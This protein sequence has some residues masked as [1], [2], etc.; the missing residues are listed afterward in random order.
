MLLYIHKSYEEVTM[1]APRWL[2]FQLFLIFFIVIGC[3]APLMAGVPEVNHTMITDVTALSFSV[4]WSANEA[5]AA[6]LEV[7]ED[8]EGLI[9]FDAAVVTPHPVESGNDSIRLAAEDNGVMKVRV[10]GLEAGN[11]Y[12][13]K[14]LT[15]S[16][17]TMDTTEYPVAPPY[18]SITTEIATVKSMQVGADEIPFSND[19]I[20]EPCYLDDG[21]TPAEGTLLIAT[22]E[23]ADYPLTSFVG[24]GVELPNAL[25]DLNNTFGRDSKEN[26]DLEQGKNLTLLNFRGI[27]GNSIVTHNVPIDE[28]LSEV[29]TAEF[30]IK[31]GWNMV[32]CQLEP[33][34][35]NVESLLEPVWDNFHSLWTLNENGDWI[36][37]TK[38]LPW[39]MNDLN[40]I[41]SLKGYWL[42][43]EA[44]YQSDTTL[45]IHGTFNEGTIS[46]NAGWNLI[47]N[48][49]I[50]TER[51]TEAISPYSDKLRV[52]WTYKDGNWLSYTPGLPPFMNDLED[53][54]PG[55]GYMVY[56]NEPHD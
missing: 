12:Y 42:V 29:K 36:S 34:T 51:I 2:V 1:G 24:D 37:Y 19:I 49:S 18:T 10:T 54:K 9:P 55:Q 6:R 50:E 14:T 45:K 26:L 43:M 28:S 4:I 31:A 25:I 7:F 15:T 32:S 38:G 3:V 33:N 39:F 5:S 53:A 44:N 48:H 20:I 11:T 40:E 23:G 56:M 47:G 22:M 41:Y 13:F 30:A 8:E 27:L 17:S 21:I 52:I 16:L 35:N 46:L